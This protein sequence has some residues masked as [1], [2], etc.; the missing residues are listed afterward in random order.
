M[1]VQIASMILVSFALWC[2]LVEAASRGS[3]PPVTVETFGKLADGSDVECLTLTNT[4]GVSV[5]LITYGATVVELTVPDRNGSFSSVVLGSDSIEVYERGFPAASV[6]GRVANRIAGA[7]FSLDGAEY[8]L[9]ANNGP[10]HLHGGRTH[11][12]RRNWQAEIVDSDEG[13]SVRFSYLSVDGEEGY[14]GNLAVTVTYTLLTDENTLRLDYSGETDKPTLINLTNHAYFNLDDG[15]N[16]GAHV[17]TL[18]ADT[19]TV[20]DETLIPTGEI[21]SVHGTPLDFTRPTPIG[22]RADQLAENRIYDHNFVLNREVGDT[23]LVLAARV[24]GASSGRTLEVWTTEPG[25]QLYTSRL[26]EPAS[27][28]ADG[29]PRPQFFCLETQHHPDSIHHPE[30]PSIVLRPGEVFRSTTEFR[31]GVE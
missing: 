16:A 21:R 25:M 15:G 7:K 17:M 6:I 24:Q 9:E 31:F 5:K 19:Y 11:F 2:P 10:N 27:R 28:R 30:F 13:Q 18:N 14:P 29:P 22:A 20:F 1:D 26:G 23:G 8:G 12:G 4:N 3:E